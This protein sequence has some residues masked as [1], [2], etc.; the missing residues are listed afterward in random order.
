MNAAVYRRAKTVYR[1]AKNGVAQGE[2]RP[3]ANKLSQA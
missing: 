3:L 2:N 1:S